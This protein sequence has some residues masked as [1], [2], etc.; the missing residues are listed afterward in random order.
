MLSIWVVIFASWATDS[1]KDVFVGLWKPMVKSQDYQSSS[2][3]WIPVLVRSEKVL[4]ERPV[5]H[6]LHHI[7]LFSAWIFTRHETA[8]V[9]HGLEEEEKESP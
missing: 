8:P 1:A 7:A 4:A 6:L 5:V 9:L 3:L 2:A